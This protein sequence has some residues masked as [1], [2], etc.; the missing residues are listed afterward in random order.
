MHVDL[1]L[2][3]QKATV[4]QEKLKAKIESEEWYLNRMIDVEHSYKTFSGLKAEAYKRIKK[5]TK[6]RTSNE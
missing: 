3:V 4:E 1:I 2:Q 6:E 5:L